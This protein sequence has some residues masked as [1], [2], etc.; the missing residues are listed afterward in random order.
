MEKYPGVKRQI[1]NFI[2]SILK[3]VPIRFSQNQKYDAQT[4]EVMKRVLK[5]DSNCVD[6]GGHEGEILRDMIRFAPSGKHYCFEPLPD[7][8]DRIK[9]KYPEATILDIALSDQAGETTFQ[10]VV[11]NPAYSG[12][13]RRQ[14]KGDEEVKEIKVKTEKLDSIVPAD[15]P[16]RLIKIDVEGGEMGVLKGAASII[17]KWKPIVIFEHGRGASEFYN[18]SPDQVFDFFSDADMK[19]SLLDSWLK[20][21]NALTREQFREQ[22]EKQLN[23]YFIAHS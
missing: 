22:Y 8:C 7:F 20:N 6:V 3:V 18:T 14:Y 16:I 4:L 11:S 5:K 2:K 13:K 1:K 12:I 23:Y 19:V 10:Y 21:N 15:L 9:S 17:R